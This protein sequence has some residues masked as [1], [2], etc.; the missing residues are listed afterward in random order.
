[1][2]PMF[3]TV[4]QKITSVAVWDRIYFYRFDGDDDDDDDDDALCDQIYFYRF[5]D[6]GDSE[7]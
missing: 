2:A 6:N 3:I 7:A 1:M 5:D 4:C